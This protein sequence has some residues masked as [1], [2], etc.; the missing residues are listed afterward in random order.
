MENV[1]DKIFS[2]KLNNQLNNNKKLSKDKF[3]VKSM[4]EKL[5]HK[6]KTSEKAI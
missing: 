4:K 3:N 1:R 2:S 5:E 6:G